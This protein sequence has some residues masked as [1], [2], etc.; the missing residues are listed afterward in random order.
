MEEYRVRM[1]TLN[2]ALRSEHTH[3]NVHVVCAVLQNI[4]E[5]GWCAH[6]MSINCLAT[7]YSM[8]HTDFCAWWGHNELRHGEMYRQ[9]CMWNISV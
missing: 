6:S 9:K 4:E 2:L 5:F 1:H 3:N 8:V 7:L